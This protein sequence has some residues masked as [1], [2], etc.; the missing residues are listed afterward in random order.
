MSTLTIDLSSVL[1]R[2]VDDWDVVLIKCERAF[3][4]KFA[5]KISDLIDEGKVN[6]VNQMLKVLFDK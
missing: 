4:T 5:E 1:K 2:Q 6:E 3:G